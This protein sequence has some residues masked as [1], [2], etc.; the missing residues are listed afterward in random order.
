MDT[1]DNFVK[2][3]KKEADELKDIAAKSDKKLDYYIKAAKK[4][5]ELADKIKKHADLLKKSGFSEESISAK[6]EIKR[7]LYEKE[8]SLFMYY[9]RKTDYN[10]AENHYN[11]AQNYLDKYLKKIKEIINKASDNIKEDLIYNKTKWSY[12]KKQSVA[13]YHAMKSKK[14][15][16]EKNFI[17]ALD[18]AR[19]A[20]DEA[21]NL[22]KIANEN[23]D[24]LGYKHKRIASGNYSAIASDVATIGANIISNK[25]EI[26]KEMFFNFLNK[27][28]DSYRYSCNAFK[29]NPAWDGYNKIKKERIDE[30]KNILSQNK[31]IWKEIYIEFE[32]EKEFLKVMKKVDTEKYN[33]IKEKTIIKEN[34]GVELWAKGSFWVFLFVVVF[35][36]GFF[37]SQTISSFLDLLVI[38]LTTEAIIVILGGL[39]L[40]STG[41]LSEANTVEVIKIAFKSQFEFIKILIKKYNK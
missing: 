13:I 17:E 23:T 2:K 41:E 22:L 34:K 7:I 15:S 30:I 39:I 29:E 18:Y 12:F 21:E 5:G 25:K 37:A 32:E 10:E 27:L 3:L 19:Q 8:Q 24:I 6:N 31:H 35:G 1:N 20:L 9:Y 26:T 4:Y 14:A 40:R 16:E 33:E 11:E 28:W 36:V 38:I